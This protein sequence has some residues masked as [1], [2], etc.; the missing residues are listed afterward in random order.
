LYNNQRGKKKILYRSNT[1][2]KRRKVLQRDAD[3][4]KEEFYRLKFIDYDK[5]EKNN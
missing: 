3:I 2:I 4:V 5:I 1:E